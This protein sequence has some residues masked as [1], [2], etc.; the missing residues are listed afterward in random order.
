VARI[1]ARHADLDWG[2][3]WRAAATG[4]ETALGASLLLAERIF[5][6]RLPA[7][8]RRRASSVASR[9]LASWLERRIATGRN[10]WDPVARGVLQ[11]VSAD[12]WPRR[13][14]IAARF[15]LRP[16]A[17]DRAALPLPAGMRWLHAPLRPALLASRFLARRSR[18]R[19]IGS[20]TAERP[21]GAAHEDRGEGR[22]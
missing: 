4:C 17:L 3:T 7:A 13:V 5:A 21:A 19:A 10:V 22:G 9:T 16:T 2:A 15:A 8:A 12:G 6:A 20:G 14:K 18:S 1:L 11:A